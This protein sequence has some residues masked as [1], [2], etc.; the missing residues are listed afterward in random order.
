MELWQASHQTIGALPVMEAEENKMNF[1]QDTILDNT[2][3]LT[4]ERTVG[5]LVRAAQSGDR[6]AFGTLFETIPIDDLH[7]S[8]APSS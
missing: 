3:L 8:D 5:E 2:A 1:T 4:K 6:E 7:A